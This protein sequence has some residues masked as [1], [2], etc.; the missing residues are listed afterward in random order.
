MKKQKILISVKSSVSSL[1]LLAV[2]GS[3]ADANTITLQSDASTQ[4]AAL[5]AGTPSAAVLARLDTSDTTGL[6]FGFVDVGAFGTFTPVPPGAPPGT[7]VV[8]IPPGDGENGYFEMSFTLP[9]S[10]A[11][12]KLTGAA[13]IDDVGRVFLN[14]NAISPSIFSSD[15]NRVTEFGN[16]TFSTQNASFFHPG[17][18]IVLISDANTGSGPSG[19]A[20][21]ANVTFG[22]QGVPDAGGTFLLL[23]IALACLICLHR[24]RALVRS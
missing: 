4:A 20:F 8:N 14:G 1:A 11:N 15:P 3:V 13:N 22:V 21:F 17:T 18:N 24:R 16:A 2:V 7:T 19:G 9:S 6:T 23:G 5:G 10:F 12:I